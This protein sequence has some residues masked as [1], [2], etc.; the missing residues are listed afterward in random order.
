[1][2]AAHA[3]FA[4]L[5]F[6]VVD[7]VHAFLGGVRGLHLASLLRRIDAM[8]AAPARRIGLSATLGDPDLARAW[9]RP[10]DPARVRL[11]LGEGGAAAPGPRLPRAG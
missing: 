6:V 10:D 1:M 5:R 3:L 2:A 4:R 8:G 9:L 7:E 11:V